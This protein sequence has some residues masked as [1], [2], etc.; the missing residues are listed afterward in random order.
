MHA[1]GISPQWPGQK[2]TRLTPNSQNTFDQNSMVVCTVIP[3]SSS[4]PNLGSLGWNRWDPNRHPLVK[5]AIWVDCGIVPGY[6][7]FVLSR[8][9]PD[10]HEKQ[11]NKFNSVCFFLIHCH[12]DHWSLFPRCYW[13][14]VYCIPFPSQ[15]PIHADQVYF[16]DQFDLVTKTYWIFSCIVL[17]SYGIDR[18]IHSVSMCEFAIN[19]FFPFRA[20]SLPFNLRASILVIIVDV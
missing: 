1:I 9:K 11:M 18:F 15:N 14:L 6:E 4:F 10:G 5:C 17:Y 12:F 8:R 19:C 13:E 20:T 2:N 3:A 7:T 16:G